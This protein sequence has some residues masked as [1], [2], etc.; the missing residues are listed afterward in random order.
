MFTTAERTRIR[1]ELIAL[2]RSDADIAGAAMVGS[3][4]RDQDDEWSD[5]DLVLQ[6]TKDGDTSVLYGWQPSGTPED[7]CFVHLD[8]PWWVENDDSPGG[9]ICL[10]SG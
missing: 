6:L 4:A 7:G 9:F 8:G 1:D 5:I 10:R 3:A 2:A